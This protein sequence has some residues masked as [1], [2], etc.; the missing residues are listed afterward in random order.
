LKT[1]FK[2]KFKDFKLLENHFS[3]FPSLFSNRNRKKFS[4]NTNGFQKVGLP[5]F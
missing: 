5:N 3:I 1:E 2:N 4:T